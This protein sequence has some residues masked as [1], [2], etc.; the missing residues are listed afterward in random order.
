MAPGKIQPWAHARLGPILPSPSEP[1][2]KSMRSFIKFA[3]I[4]MKNANPKQSATA[5]GSKNP[6]ALESEPPTI[7]GTAA[8]ESVLGRA[9]KNHAS[10]APG[11]S[12]AAL[13]ARASIPF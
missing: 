5:A 3:H 11:F 10:G 12:R 13:T 8:A 7:T 1:F 2:P 4:C 6:S 9:A